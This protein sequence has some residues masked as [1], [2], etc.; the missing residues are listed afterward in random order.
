MTVFNVL[1][2]ISGA[3]FIGGVGVLRHNGNFLRMVMSVHGALCALGAGFFLLADI[4]DDAAGASAGVCV[5]FFAA[6]SL[7]ASLAAYGVYLKKHA[8]EGAG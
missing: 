7:T 1:C 3:L 8:R 5:L 4:Y 2:L 6:V